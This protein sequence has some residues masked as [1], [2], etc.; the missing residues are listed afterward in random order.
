MELDLGPVMSFAK[1][2][3]VDETIKSFFYKH[4]FDGHDKQNVLNLEFVMF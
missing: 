1:A 4:R 2:H 3:T